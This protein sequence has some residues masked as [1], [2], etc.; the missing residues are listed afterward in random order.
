MQFRW[1]VRATNSNRDWPADLHPV[2]RQVLSRRRVAS[3]EE[4]TLG[5]GG[6]LPVG[7]FAELDEAVA[8][9]LAHRQKRITIVGDFD[10]DGATSTALVK[11][12]L[13]ALGFVSTNY[14][15][16]DRFELGYG[17]SPKVVDLVRSDAPDLIVTVDNGI[18]SLEG[19]AEARRAGIDVLITDHHLPGD[20]L[21]DANA[22]VNPN[23]PG[24]SFDGKALAGVGVA[25][26]LMAALARAC[27]Q[28]NIP[29]AYLDLVALGTVADLVPLTHYNRILVEQGLRRM[30]RGLCRPGL[31]AL[32]A[33]AGKDLS[34]AAASDLGFQIGPR[35]NAAGRLEDM[36]RGIE[37]LLTDDAD[38]AMTLAKE[39]DQLNA[40]R[41]EIEARM[42][43]EAQQLVDGVSSSEEQF[44]ICLHSQ[45]WHQGVV[46]LVASRLKDRWHK[47]TVAFAGAGNG[48]LKGSGRSIPGFHIRDALAEIA[49]DNP[50]LIE[51]FGGHAMAAGLTITEANF[52]AFADAFEA[53]TRSALEAEALVREH[54]IDGTLAPEELTLEV[55][56]LL[57]FA[58]PWGQHFPEPAFAGRFMLAAQ[59]LVG[60]RHL[61]MRLIPESGSEAIDAIAFNTEPV[62]DG[63]GSLVDVRYR[64][65]VNDYDGK[66]LQLVVEEL[67]ANAPTVEHG[68]LARDGNR[69]DSN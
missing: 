46:G 26:Y 57:R 69:R 47:P 25:F 1:P 44:T 33:V 56:Q 65:D 39:L 31:N 18:S 37:C 3:A 50:D 9:L 10:A 16:P 14:V 2:L 49:A 19:V 36:R 30:R 51:T 35:I 41:R 45:A 40:D 60:E 11:L 8:L 34:A 59:R 42:R 43:S 24:T 15:V 58:M 17:L 68:K 52:S 7:S 63:Q 21:P 48:Y 13:D 29:A 61:K 4:L 62:A 38:A 22:I 6:L 20:K 54:W 27:G 23:A 66:R 32:F 55:A 12:C 67:S 64:M 5:L 28:P 53:I